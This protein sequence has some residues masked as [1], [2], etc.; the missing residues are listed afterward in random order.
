TTLSKIGDSVT[1]TYTVQNAG[2]KDSPALVNVL[3]T[4]DNG[5]PNDTSDDFTPTFTG[6]DT[7]GNGKLDVDE[8]WTYSATRQI[9]IGA[10]DPFVNTAV[11]HANPD[12]FKNDITATAY[13]SINL[14]QP[15]IKLTKSGPPLSK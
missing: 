7:N 1:Y 5:T 12:G 3:L 11:V 15:A 10:S 9:P 4:D 13:F 6:G 8:T 2:S 14:F